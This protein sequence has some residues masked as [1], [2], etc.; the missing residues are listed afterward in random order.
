[1][2][3]RLTI[4]AMAKRIAARLTRDAE[5][6]Y[7]IDDAHDALN[8]ILDAYLA[9]R[10]FSDYRSVEKIVAEEAPLRVIDVG[11]VERAIRAAVRRARR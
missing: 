1:M 3:R 4:R 10:F 8:I 11:R 5:T 9:A 7:V 2:K 6:R